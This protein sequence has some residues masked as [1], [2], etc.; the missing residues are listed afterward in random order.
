M[1]A[2]SE[3]MAAAFRLAESGRRAAWAQVYALRERLAELEGRLG[4]VGGGEVPPALAADWFTDPV[5]GQHALNFYNHGYDDARSV[6]TYALPDTFRE[7]QITSILD[8]VVTL[9]AENS[10]L[11]RVASGRARGWLRNPPGGPASLPALVQTLG[12]LVGADSDGD[13]SE[14]LDVDGVLDEPVVEYFNLRGWPLPAR[15]A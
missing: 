14:R 15:A 2:A 13:F 4:A 10:T 6:Y 3:D 5:W 8:A 7:K 12:C 9:S 11:W 1:T